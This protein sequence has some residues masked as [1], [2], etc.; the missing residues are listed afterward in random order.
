MNEDPTKAP[1][2]P[3]SVL[4]VVAESTPLRMRYYQKPN[5]MVPARSGKI[6]V[7]FTMVERLG[8]TTMGVACTDDPEK[9][10]LLDSMPSVKEISEE[11]YHA[12][13]KKKASSAN[14]YTFHF[15]AEDQT[16][17]VKSP[18]KPLPTSE[19]EVVAASVEKIAAPPTSVDLTLG[20]VK[21]SK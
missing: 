18:P 17:T 21:P 6:A 9:Q 14:E 8:T 11:F 13:L 2:K 20:D 16:R 1:T 15:H 7:A 10:K 5:P 3:K 19:E 12:R 4:E